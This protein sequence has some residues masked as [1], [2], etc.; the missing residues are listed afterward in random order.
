MVRKGDRVVSLSSGD[1]YDVLEAS[2]CCL[3]FCAV[4]FHCLLL[5]LLFHLIV[6]FGLQPSSLSLLDL[7]AAGHEAAC[8]AAAY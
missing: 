1:T 3:F 6:G 8:L 7:N 2:C 5:F 4:V